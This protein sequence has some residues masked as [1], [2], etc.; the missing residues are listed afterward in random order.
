MELWFWTKF[1]GERATAVLFVVHVVHGKHIQTP[2]SCNDSVCYTC[3][4][5]P[6][7]VYR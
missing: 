5:Q 4:T 1:A 6:S 2:T 3:P 7:A